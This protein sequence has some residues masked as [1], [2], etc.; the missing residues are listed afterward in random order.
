MSL[1]K[2]GA[3]GNAGVR[4]FDLIDDEVEE[5]FVRWPKSRGRRS[6]CCI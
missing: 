5:G 6:S 1:S 4:D 3:V 2:N